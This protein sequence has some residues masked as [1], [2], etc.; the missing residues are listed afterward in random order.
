MRIVLSFLVVVVTFQYSVSQTLF[1]HKHS[2]GVGAGYISQYFIDRQ[3]SPLRY[4]DATVAYSMQYTRNTRVGHHRIIIGYNHGTFTTPAG[5]ANRMFEKYDRVQIRGGY[6]HT[7][8]TFFDDKLLLMGG[9]YFDNYFTY[10]DHYY[11][12]TRNEIF[13]EYVSAFHP[14]LEV[15][16][17]IGERSEFRSAAALSAI[18]YMVNSPY[19]VRGP[20]Q[21]SFQFFDSY[22]QLDLLISYRHLFTDRMHIDVQYNFNYYRHT[23]PLELKFARDQ[24]MIYFGY[25]M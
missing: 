15:F 4:Q 5:K 2:I 19:S 11:F 3:A 14:V 25:R 6:V 9:F 16:Y 21:H 8:S 7:I 22:R 23:V 10:R 12:A 24:A 18:A 13:V 17:R 1:E 20:V